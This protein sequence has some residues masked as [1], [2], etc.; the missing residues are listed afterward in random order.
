MANLTHYG[1]PVVTKDNA[2]DLGRYG[3]YRKTT[4]TLISDDIVAVGTKVATIGGVVETTVPCHIGLDN[5]GH[6]YPIER[7][8]LE[9][10]YEEVT[11][12]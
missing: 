10:T 8:V 9:N 5:E 2:K 3:S 1:G 4:T 12:E 6:P 11:S 7:S